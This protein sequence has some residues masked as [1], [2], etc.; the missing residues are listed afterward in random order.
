MREHRRFPAEILVEQQMLW[1][2]RNPFLTAHDMGDA[3]KMVIDNIGEMVSRQAVRFH[4]HLH[5]DNIIFE[6]NFAAQRVLNN[7][8]ARCGNFHTD[9]VRNT[10]A[11]ELGD[12]F[13]G[14]CQAGAIIFWRLLCRHLCGAGGC[15][16]LRRTIA[17]ERMAIG[18]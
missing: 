13:S 6:R 4:Q 14:Q 7:T 11:V 12:I 8:S 15:E 18:Q 16:L 3:H 9:N 17:F 1:C 2:R 5:V 10:V